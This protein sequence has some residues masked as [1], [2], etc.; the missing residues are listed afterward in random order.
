MYSKIFQ[1]GFL[2]QSLDTMLPVLDLVQFK[3]FGHR[4]MCTGTGC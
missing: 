4:A 1:K 3:G 2:T